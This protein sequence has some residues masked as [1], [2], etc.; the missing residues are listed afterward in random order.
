MWVHL[1]AADVDHSSVKNLKEIVPTEPVLVFERYRLDVKRRVLTRD[2]HR[3]PLSGRPLL[4]L[5]AL[6][7]RLGEVVSNRELET[8]LWP[9]S[10][11]ADGTLRVHISRVQRI[12]GPT[13]N[14]LRFIENHFRRG[15]RMSVPVRRCCPQMPPGEVT[16][17]ME[18][19]ESLTGQPQIIGRS[20]CIA[21]IVAIL[22]QRPIVTL[23]GPGGIGK[24][25]VAMAVS[26]E[27]L[28]EHREGVWVVDLAAVD[29][30]EAVANEVAAT[31]GLGSRLPDP[32]AGVLEFLQTR[33]GLLV[34]DNCEH[35]LDAAAQLA[36]AVA[37][38]AARVRV[39]AT[40]REQLY[41]EGERVYRLEPLE[42]PPLPWTREK[43]L[44]ATA[45]LLFTM[46]AAA[47]TDVRF[48]DEQLGVVAQL[49]RRLSGNPLA[50]EIAAARLDLLGLGGL[51]AALDSG[52][53]LSI[54]GH[55]TR[56]ARHWSLRATLDWSY[57]LLSP[58]EQALFRRLGM[59][60]GSF[61]LAAAAE[62]MSRSEV[63]VETAVVF[64]GL[65][66]L[67][68][69]SMLATEQVG[70]EIRYKLHET[71]RA[72]AL[73]KLRECGELELISH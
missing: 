57:G 58:L 37:R 33:A 23:T 69:K 4:V 64:E 48:S 17:P 40:S 11:M 27:L 72:Y 56:V 49:C 44:A 21:H 7:E 2:G 8:L 24:T 35:V 32:L 5:T 18:Q 67:T 53:A 39:L 41:A 55:R 31:L 65:L 46:R 60:C 9:N 30:C 63:A 73:Y 68:S 59:F 20:K 1:D 71:T 15:Y 25:A 45:V 70:A 54:V 62:L 66:G 52:H 3:V 6:V 16:E 13:E 36:Q 50:I 22:R 28:A 12:L 29:S 61:D 34:L 47:A 26:R 43:L 14:G 38:A 51:I 42:V 10:Y 19:P